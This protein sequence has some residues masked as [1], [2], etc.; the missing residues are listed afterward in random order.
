MRANNAR[1][2]ACA[3]CVAIGATLA[4]S[5]PKLTNVVQ[6]NGVVKAIHESQ[7]VV[8][9]DF[10]L[11]RDGWSRIEDW[12]ATGNGVTTFSKRGVAY[13]GSVAASTQVSN[14]LS[15]TDLTFAVTPDQQVQVAS[16]HIN[17]MFDD[18]FWA[19]STLSDGVQ[20]V[21]FN[22]NFLQGFAKSGYSKVLTVTKPN[23]FKL[24]ITT[25]NTVAWTCKDSRNY[26]VG[27]E[28]RLDE[29][30]GTW[31][32]DQTNTYRVNLKYSDATT[33]EPD[34]P[35]V[36]A[37]STEWHRLPQ[38]ASVAAGSALDWR[39]PNTLPSGNEGWMTVN[40][41]GQ[42][43]FPNNLNQPR[44][45]YGANLSHY[46]CFPSKG[47][48]ILLAENLA[49]LGYNSVRLHHF[50]YVLVRSSE[51]DSTSID[52]EMMEKLN[53]F[54]YELKRRGFYISI[55]LHS[56]RTPRPDEILPG[57][58][59]ENDYKAL[60]LVS[61]AAR[62]N[63]LTF[64]S[65]LLNTMNPFTGLKWKDEPAI[66]W[67]A[68]GNE[69]GPYWFHWPRNDIKA[70][71]DTAVGGNWN[72]E[73]TT[74]SQAAVRLAS[75]TAAYLASQLRSMGVRSL[76]TNLNAGFQRVLAVGRAD[77]DYVDNHLY[78]AHP[79]GFSLPIVQKNTTPLRKIEEIGWFA[80]S[81]ISGKPFTVTEFDAVAPNQF[82]AEFGLMVGAMGAV[83]KWDGMWRFQYADNVSRALNVE[84]MNLFSVAAD[85]LS[86]ATERAI[87]ALYLRGD[88]ASCDLPY[89]IA[90]PL[91][92]A[93]QFE[94]REEPV[95]KQSVLAKPIAQIDDP[96][97][98]G[99]GIVV[100]GNSQNADGSVKADL[101]QLS[102]G[103]R[104]GLTCAAI[105]SEGTTHQSGPLKVTFTKTRASVYLTSVDRQPLSNS[106]RMLLAHLTDVQNS[107]ATFTGIERKELT[108]WGTLP[109][110][111][112]N[113]TADVILSLPNAKYFKVYQLDLGGKRIATLSTTRTTSTLRFKASTRQSSSGTGVI[114][115][116]IVSTR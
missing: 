2:F 24:T 52:P 30:S 50:D 102:L 21:A 76:F 82:R 81:R 77:L 106:K 113:G 27:F 26:F 47:Q 96:S 61:P 86:L 70:M 116:E 39:S 111:V 105:G 45:F 73:S 42:F 89:Y 40:A 22:P 108:S 109:H 74:G 12:E 88:L 57:G 79:T 37:E 5:Q 94:I 3:I 90:N 28:L 31:P 69:N 1:H 85:P 17:M 51:S 93:N 33:T 4:Q 20:T 23:G 95:V 110:L 25:P 6:S 49:R 115:Y 58:M 43:A 104:T 84:P 68:L 10:W 54:V 46:A 103:I 34:N 63:Y 41:S 9:T 91:A 60:L 80:A 100:D 56:L 114:Y 65:N 8:T 87:V 55:D 53:Y 67:M 92:T 97:S 71:L 75:E 35:V 7:A 107:G 78:F 38:V 66:A 112:R 99:S 13:P 16:G 101:N 72:P 64:A 29:R 19:G 11:F 15:G 18:A 14:S 62:Q 98:S 59:N 36:I 32:A 44:R 48:A 83:Q